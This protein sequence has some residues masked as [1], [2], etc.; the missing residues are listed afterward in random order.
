MSNI[1]VNFNNIVGAM[2]IMHGVNNGPFV[3]GN[4]QVRGN[5][6]TYM[7]CR[8]PYARTHDASFFSGYGG[9]HTVDVNFIFTDFD[10]DVNDP[11]SYDFARYITYLPNQ[12]TSQLNDGNVGI[13]GQ[14]NYENT[15]LS[16]NTR[17][18]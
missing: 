1:R 15:L 16:G 9:N 8:I 7:A 13:I 17:K 2:K 12:N 6:K 10:A 14:E 11:A 4:D 18:E 3:S 5:Q